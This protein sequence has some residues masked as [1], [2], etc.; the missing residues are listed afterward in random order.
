MCVFAYI[1]ERGFKYSASHYLHSVYWRV[2]G[3]LFASIRLNFAQNNVPIPVVWYQHSEN[4]GSF[5]H[6]YHN[7]SIGI[8]K[9]EC[10][11]TTNA[12]V[13]YF[14]RSAYVSTVVPQS[15]SHFQS[16]FPVKTIFNFIILYKLSIKHRRIQPRFIRENGLQ[17][18]SLWVTKQ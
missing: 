8:I 3:E 16:Q 10:L 14:D 15:Y 13:V 9:V 5:A 2:V 12:S 18:Q 7:R 11:T 4:L 1:L 6:I 17:A